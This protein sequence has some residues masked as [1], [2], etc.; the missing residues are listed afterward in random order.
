M[1]TSISRTSRVGEAH[2]RY[3]LARCNREGWLRVDDS[4][5]HE[6]YW[7]EY[8]NSDGQP[9][10]FLHGG[11]G[12]AS[13][14]EISRVFDPNRYRLILFDQRG[15]GKS[16]PSVARDGRVALKHN[17]TEY[18]VRDIMQ[19]RNHL[20]VYPKMHLFGGSWGST[21]AMAYA[22]HHPETVA[23]L[24]L[25][26]IFLG[27]TEDWRYIYQGNAAVYED[28]P[29]AMPTPGTYTS[30]P[31]AWRHYVEFI[32]PAKRDDMIKAYKDLFDMVPRNDA[33]HRRAREAA[34]HW[35]LWESITS[36]LVPEFPGIEG[37]TGIDRA[38]CE[39]HVEAHYATADDPLR[40]GYL[41]DH[42]ARFA[43]IPVH[44]VHG[45]YDQLCSLTQ[46]EIVVSALKK[47]GR[48][49][50]SYIVTSAGHSMFERQNYLALTKIMD[51]L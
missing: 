15:T 21:L 33:E 4:P 29:Y 46:A 16:H 1:D 26:G 8:G 12:Y 14:P 38:I 3:P 22:I 51:E 9:V 25:R 35:Y 41:I 19:L 2:W 43:D 28:N 10:M 40:K 31:D 36:N 34:C 50:A 6:I 45:R 5:Q 18:L 24:I 17:T 20:G 39:A 42:V 32:P 11:P 27:R 49:P 7:A 48:R 13:D 37:R 47:L 23:T 44:I 30:Y